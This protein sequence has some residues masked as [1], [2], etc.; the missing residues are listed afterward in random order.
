MALMTLRL[1][2]LRNLAVPLL[3]ILVAQVALIT[4]VCFWRPSA[5]WDATTTRR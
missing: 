1:W 5:S 4:L 2:E 3:A